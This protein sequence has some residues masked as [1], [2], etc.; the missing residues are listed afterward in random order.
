MIRYKSEHEISIMQK[1]GKLVHD[2]LEEVSTWI[3]PGVTTAKLDAIAEDYIR[4]HNGLPGFKGY[5]GY[6]ATLCVSVN[7]EVVH[8]I[9]G[10]RILKEGNMVSI[11]CGT[12]VDGYYGDHARTFSVGEIPE[13]WK[14]LMTVTEECLNFGICKAISGNHL[15]DIGHAIQTH[16]EEHGFSV[17]RSLVGHGIGRKLHEEPQVPNYGHP[18]RGMR[19]KP[20]LVIAIEPMINL[21]THEV[22]TLRDGWTI[23]TRDRKVSAHFEHTIAV[24][25]NEPLILTNG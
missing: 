5:N 22:E 16:A 1:A 7:E 23:V 20:G 3:K 19:L 24:T 6:P 11:D 25:E 17:I 2:T 18:G 12:I 10:S 13:V 15:L 21:G 9:P 8:G 14:R 4:S